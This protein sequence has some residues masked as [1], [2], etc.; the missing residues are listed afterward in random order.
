MSTRPGAYLAD[1]GIGADGPLAAFSMFVL[2][3][4]VIILM[5]V[6]CMGTSLQVSYLFSIQCISSSKRI[7]ESLNRLLFAVTWNPFHI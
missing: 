4:L 3:I 6:G 7:V 5:L 1:T 2:G